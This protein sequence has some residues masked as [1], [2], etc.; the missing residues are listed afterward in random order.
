ML[1]QRL[2]CQ[3]PL[4]VSCGEGLLC[5]D[6]AFSVTTCCSSSSC[7]C[8]QSNPAS[9]E[10]TVLSSSFPFLLL[11]QFFQLV[12][13]IK[14]LWSDSDKD[15]FSVPWSGQAHLL[16]VKFQIPHSD[17]TTV[18]CNGCLALRSTGWTCPRDCI[19][20][21]SWPGSYL[22]HFPLHHVFAWVLPF[23]H[24]QQDLSTSHSPPCRGGAQVVLPAAAAAAPPAAGG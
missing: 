20:L 3:S 14:L 11:F 21:T 6:F 15:L 18:A 17:R 24:L 13:T 5:S 8:Y 1:A 22:L 16:W 19:D 10:G 7:I 2:C 9:T 4:L 23:I 12:F